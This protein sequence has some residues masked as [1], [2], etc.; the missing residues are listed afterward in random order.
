MELK[1]FQK[2]LTDVPIEQILNY[3]PPQYYLPYDTRPKEQN[4]ILKVKLE[5]TTL[6]VFR[7]DANQLKVYSSLDLGIIG[8]STLLY[9]LVD[10]LTIDGLSSLLEG[11]IYENKFELE[12][13]SISQESDYTNAILNVSIKRDEID[14]WMNLYKSGS[15]FIMPLSF[16]KQ[17]VNFLYV[18]E[19]S[20]SVESHNNRPGLHHTKG[21]LESSELII[22]FNPSRIFEAEPGDIGYISLFNPDDAL[23]KRLYTILNNYKKPFTFN[24]HS[25]SDFFLMLKYC[26]ATQESINKKIRVIDMYLDNNIV[27]VTICFLTEINGLKKR[28]VAARLNDIY[29]REIE[30]EETKEAS[31]KNL[32]LNPYILNNGSV[33]STE[34]NEGLLKIKALH[35][36]SLYKAF[37][38][39]FYVQQPIQ[40]I[41]E[42]YP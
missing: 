37:L 9:Y 39:L 4:R 35:N 8:K 33:L 12:P 22:N 28:T 24:L 34:M 32:G 2:H 26:V 36:I 11:P 41:G 18:N 19:N 1:E 16:N 13:F 20:L 29:S 21:V 31:V 10:E 17:I 38:K 27:C 15:Q 25:A 3:L 14:E 6:F 5:L 30:D 7:N 23:F 42:R 40:S